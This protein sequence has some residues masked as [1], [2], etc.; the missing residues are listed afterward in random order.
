MDTIDT[1][2]TVDTSNTKNTGGKRLLVLLVL[3]LA[4]IGTGA[5]FVP[6]EQTVANGASTSAQAAPVT[7]PTIQ[8]ARP[9]QETMGDTFISLDLLI[10]GA[11]NSFYGVG[12]AEPGNAN[13][14]WIN[15]TR[16]APDPNPVVTG[17]YECDPVPGQKFDEVALAHS[18]TTL[19]VA[20]IDHKITSDKPR[21]IKVVLCAFAGAYSV[22]A[23]QEL[24]E[25]GAGAFTGYINQS[26]PVDYD[27]I[28]RRVRTVVHDE[29][30]KN[31][32]G[33]I[34]VI[35]DNMIPKVT[36]ALR[37]ALVADGLFYHSDGI[38]ARIVE[39]T[40]QQVIR[41][42]YDYKVPTTGT[43]VPRP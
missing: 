39:T 42:L 26:D 22:R 29:L 31:P 17:E 15:I 43:P 28:E 23:G 36:E 2:D 11:G 14:T 4:L 8:V 24:E 27:E 34:K 41:G 16:L 30:Y 7:A 6:N 37:Q 18:G 13:D 19:L 9:V 1:I 21:P 5:T 32:G 35:V 3:L 40:W 38:Y 20:G 10:D 25:G 12:V 33:A